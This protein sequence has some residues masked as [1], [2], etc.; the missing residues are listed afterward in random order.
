MAEKVIIKHY[1]DDNILITKDVFGT[2]PN[3]L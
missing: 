3:N 1:E 2:D